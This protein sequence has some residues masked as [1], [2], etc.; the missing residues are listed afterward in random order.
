[1]LLIEEFFPDSNLVLKIYDILESTQLT[2]R[3]SLDEMEF[4]KWYS[5]T[6]FEQSK[7]FG[8]ND[9]LWISDKGNLSTSLAFKIDAEDLKII[10]LLP[11]VTAFT[12]HKLFVELTSI[13][14]TIKWPNDILF[15]GKK[16]AGILV[17][18]VGEGKNNSMGVIVGVGINIRKQTNE[19]ISQETAS[20]EEISKKELNI[21]VDSLALQFATKL[22][23]NIQILLSQG[24]LYFLRYINDNLEFFA[25]EKIQITD[26]FDKVVI[27]NALIKKISNDG[28]LIVINSLN[29]EQNLIYSG[30]ISIL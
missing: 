13:K 16:L 30:R 11:L 26:N 18:S 7:A 17:Q 5:Y 20:L 28:A 19:L 25:H 1:M 8:S 10:N 9:R 24:F 22:I 21:H 29:N 15:K 4:G 14:T 3:Q 2:A 27:P 23:N 6:A 12:L